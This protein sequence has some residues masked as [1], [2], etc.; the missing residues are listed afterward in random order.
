MAK[1]AI[2]ILFLSL[3]LFGA[4]T[5][6]GIFSNSFIGTSTFDPGERYNAS[7]SISAT[8]DPAPNVKVTIDL[9][10]GTTVVA[11]T[12]QFFACH[13]NGDQYVCTSGISPAGPFQSF[14]SVTLEA[15]HDLA[16]SISQLTAR[17]SSDNPDLNTFNDVFKA[18]ITTR[19]A[20]VVTTNADS[21]DGSLRAQIETMNAACGATLPCKIVFAN[22]M[23]IAPLSPLPTITVCNSGI[24]AGG[25]ANAP[26]RVALVGTQL[27]NG[28]GLEIRT[29]CRPGAF[30]NTGVTI[31]RLAIGGFPE[32]GIGITTSPRPAGTSSVGVLHTVRECYIGTDATGTVA[33]PNHYRGIATN[34]PDASVSIFQNTIA[35]NDASGIAFYSVGVASVTSNR[36]AANGA[37]GVFAAN[38][39]LTVTTNEITN[40][41]QYG[42]STIGPVRLVHGGNILR[43]NGA[44]PLDFNM[45][46]PSNGGPLRPPILT[47]AFYDAAKDLTIIRGHLTGTNDQSPTNEG[48]FRISFGAGTR[49]AHGFVDVEKIVFQGFVQIVPIKSGPFDIAFEATAKGDYRGQLIVGSTVYAPF[50]DVPNID[51]SEFSEP[52]IVH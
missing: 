19:R 13:Q 45:D 8:G 28:S 48:T 43:G 23:L 46:G 44:Q 33:L 41:G 12:S 37:S 31:R 3:P 40:N 34:A 15:S 27:R 39:D 25:A 5:D 50:G 49:N 47:D 24:D 14:I 10:P 36:I 2:L 16:G 32:N 17:I 6:L 35:S 20:L 29:N 52:V 11:A 21:G 26:L 18:T 4:T 42:I 7:F 1:R 51:G 38:G 9:P 22:D 30:S